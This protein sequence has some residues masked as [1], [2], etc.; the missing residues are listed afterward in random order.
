VLNYDGTLDYNNANW[1]RVPPPVGNWPGDNTPYQMKINGAGTKEALIAAIG[2]VGKK[3]RPTDNLLLHTNNH[4][5]NSPGVSLIS[6]SGDDTTPTDLANAIKGLPK[7]NALMVMMEQCFSGGF[8]DPIVQASPATC[9]SV[10]TAVDANHV[11]A[12]GP[13]Y[14]PFALQWICA[15]AKANPDGSA[16]MP[17][18]MANLEGQVTAWDAF[19][20]AKA[21]DPATIDDRQFGQNTACG[22]AATLGNGRLIVE[23]PPLWQYLFPWEIL[24]DPGPEQIVQLAQQVAQRLASGDVAAAVGAS[25]S[26]QPNP[27]VKIILSGR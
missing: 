4:G 25:I 12:G 9:T 10:A 21:T 2:A 16:L 20:Y 17:S 26:N 14:D 23:V 13:E 22:G 11:S 3:L 27:L 15:M 19:A 18:P 7:F 1:Q 8:I 5:S 6:Y 24:P